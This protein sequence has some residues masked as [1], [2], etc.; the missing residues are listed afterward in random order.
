MK[1]QLGG[2]A[3]RKSARP[4]VQETS[5][6]LVDN[7]LNILEFLGDTGAY[8]QFPPGKASFNLRAM[9]RPGMQHAL[10]GAVRQARESE[11]RPRR[12][13]I[14]LR[15]DGRVRKVD[16][17]VERIEDPRVD[18]PAF[19]VLF[20]D[21]TLEPSV[22]PQEPNGRQEQ[23]KAPRRP[24]ATKHV[25]LLQ[26]KLMATKENLKAIVEEHEI[27]L[28]KLIDSNLALE[29]TTTELEAANAELEAFNDELEYSNAEL[30]TAL[31]QRD[32]AEGARKS[33]EEQIGHAQKLESLG[34]LAGGIAHD[35][36]N[37]LAAM[38]GFADLA[39]DDLPR[40]SPVRPH[41]EQVVK[42]AQTATELTKQL[43][44]Y[45]GGGR[46]TVRPVNLS[47]LT[48]EMGRLLEA[49]ISKKASLRYRVMPD[50]PPVEADAGQI[51]QLV[52]NLVTNGSD[53][54]GDR[55]GVIT[56]T[57]GVMDADRAYLERTYFDDGLPEGRYVYVE[58]NDDGCGMDEDTKDRIFDPF[59]TTK[60]TGR[61]LGL[62]AALGI[63][64][65]HRGAMK[66]D[67]RPG[68]GS[69]FRV[70][71]PL[72]STTL[73]SS[74]ADEPLDPGGHSRHGTILVVDDQ[75]EVRLLAKSILEKRGF[76][77]VLAEDGQEA[78]GL[79]RTHADEIDAVLLDLKMPHM[80]GEEVMAVLRDLR[81][82]VGI[83]LSSGYAGAEF[84][85]LLEDDDLTSFIQKPYRA[86][87]L[88]N[89]LLAV[90]GAEPGVKTK[91]VGVAGQ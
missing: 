5:G 34:V 44:A 90:I 63:V 53:A 55:D 40:Q 10:F 37:L 61:G 25:S 12:E 42:A 26:Q 3:A 74:A 46:F 64:H 17:A 52:M 54:I 81:P 1:R 13:G 80:D 68:R 27:T 23:G 39:L 20:E 28:R 73:P 19:R 2:R 7:Q 60:A 50:L 35:F 65:G 51:Q 91:L 9:A 48:E 33:L 59:F 18:G 70:L 66:L 82:Q 32:E 85:G 56:L 41:V 89:I 49:V 83:V 76:E 22:S 15:R 69:S 57:T 16:I 79:F 30:E 11:D 4:L 84:A 14:L 21:R 47:R 8:L 87:E 88:I 67:T 86:H 78:V 38:L 6:V 24:P 58:V 43:L 31:R 36:N 45:S 71:F 29:V 75:P 77:T 72:S 62:A